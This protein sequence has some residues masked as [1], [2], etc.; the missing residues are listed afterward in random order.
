MTPT[1]PLSMAL[2]IALSACGGQAAGSTWQAGVPE[3]TLPPQP[4]L[5]VGAGAEETESPLH[6]V[7]AGRVFPDGRIAV[8]DAG[9]GGVVLYS[10]EGRRIAQLGRKG[11]GPGEFQVP[12]WVGTRGDTI[13]VWD[14]SLKRL[15]AFGPDHRLV[16]T[17]AVPD[18]EGMF[19]HLV[20]TMADGSLV[21]D[22]GP[23][24]LAM[25]GAEPGLRRDSVSYMRFAADGTALGTVVRVPGDALYVYERDTGFGW[26]EAPLGPRTIAVASPHGLFVAEG[27]SGEIN[28][29]GT[30]GTRTR[31]M[32][33]PHEP[34][35]ITGADVSRYRE[36]RL[37]AVGDGPRRAELEAALQRALLPDVAPPLAGFA[38]DA[39]GHAWVQEQPRPGARD[40]WWA[41]LSTTGTLQARVRI[42][43]ALEVLDVGQD[44][45]LGLWRD[46]MDVPSV[47]LYPVGKP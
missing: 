43:A 37:A 25:A 31:L 47:R 22:P 9:L 44:Y 23:D 30:D 35:R 5:E 6:I 46:E 20:G 17:L 41:V 13:L 40:A 34:W 26:M 24:A 38:V 8:A 32:R 1:P 45:V 12:A 4:A 36:S 10:A 11:E 29:Y 19:P 42:P 27:A 39:Q 33:S 14:Q 3:W 16:G 18:A 15:S 7:L 21:M 2:A 28:V